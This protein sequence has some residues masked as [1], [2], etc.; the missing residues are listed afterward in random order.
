MPFLLALLHVLLF[1]PAQYVPAGSVFP[2]AAPAGAVLIQSGTS[3]G[4]GG[5][6]QNTQPFTQNAT[7]GNQ[8]LLGVMNATNATTTVSSITFTCGTFNLVDVVQVS[9]TS[10]MWVYQGSITSSACSQVVFN[11][12]TAINSIVIFAEYSGL[13]ASPVDCFSTAVSGIGTGTAMNSGSCTTTHANDILAGFIFVTNN[14]GGTLTSTIGS[15]FTLRVV[16]ATSR[17]FQD[18]TV[19]V[20]GTYSSL[21]TYSSSQPYITRLVALKIAP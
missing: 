15:G 9:A 20:T 8:M 16:S 2:T 18:Q 7:S 11:F 10:E 1:I 21:A 4:S 14:P 5:G 12:S 19:A 3:G 13:A 17:G 6:L